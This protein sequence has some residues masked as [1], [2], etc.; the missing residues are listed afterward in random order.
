MR[1][2]SKG[3]IEDAGERDA[4]AG[5]DEQHND[6]NYIQDPLGRGFKILVGGH[7][8]HGSHAGSFSTSPFYKP[9]KNI[10]GG[11]DG[12]QG[13]GGIMKEV[14]NEELLLQVNRLKE[15]INQLHRDK[16]KSGFEVFLELAWGTIVF[17]AVIKVL[18]S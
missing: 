3:D 9:R 1:E 4:L 14:S 13:K 10:W 2:P 18:F 17:F 8:N 16:Q 11:G 7:M 6:L 12:N 15:S 5:S